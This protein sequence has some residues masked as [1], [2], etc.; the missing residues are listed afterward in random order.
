MLLLMSSPSIASVIS[1][2]LTF[3]AASQHII[4]LTK[5]LQNPDH[6]KL[7]ANDNSGREASALLS[8]KGWQNGGKKVKATKTE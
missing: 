7:R 3:W 2:Q 1:A 6:V 4:A 5:T 8:G